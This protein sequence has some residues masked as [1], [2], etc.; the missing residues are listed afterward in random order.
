MVFESELGSVSNELICDEAALD[1][2]AWLGARNEGIGGAEPGLGSSAD[3]DAD[4]AGQAS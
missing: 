4:P 2:G 1:S 3:Y